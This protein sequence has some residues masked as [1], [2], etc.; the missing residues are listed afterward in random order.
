MTGTGTQLA[1]ASGALISLGL[2]LA[3]WR[4]LPAEPDLAEALERLAP[5]TARGRSLREET[6]TP[7]RDTYER[8]GRGL[9]RTFR[10]W[11]GRR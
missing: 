11:D 1:L 6:T 5:L 9:W 8:V 3:V 10:G 4:L 2:V 7:P